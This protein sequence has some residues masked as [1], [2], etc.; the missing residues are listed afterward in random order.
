MRKIIAVLICLVMVAPAFAK[1]DKEKKHKKLPPGL[2]KKL[3]RTSELPPGWRKKIMKGEILDHD[4]YEIGR[5]HPVDIGEYSLKPEV[6]T[7]VMRIEDRIFRI[8]NDTREILEVIG[9]KTDL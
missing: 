3:E 5:N 2:H 1:N 4:L 7:R 9:I 6:G 8:K